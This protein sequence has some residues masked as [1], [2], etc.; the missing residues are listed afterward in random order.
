MIV[1]RLALS[2]MEILSTHNCYFFLNFGVKYAYKRNN[3]SQKGT[4]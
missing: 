1:A 2:S 4:Y 3:F